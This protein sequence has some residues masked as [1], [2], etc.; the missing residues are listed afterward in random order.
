MRNATTIQSAAT[1]LRNAAD[2][3]NTLADTF[4]WMNALFSSIERCAQEDGAHPG[5]LLSEIA[6]MAAMGC[7]LS[8]DW[9]AIAESMSENTASK[10]D[11]ARNDAEVANG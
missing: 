6:R 5:V 11:T 3:L 2:E 7:Y 10:C 4:G 8:S 1:A 9:Q